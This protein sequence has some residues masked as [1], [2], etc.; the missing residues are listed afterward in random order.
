MS[1]GQRIAFLESRL[2]KANARI[3]VLEARLCGAK[4]LAIDIPDWA[5]ALTRQER[6]LVEALRKA[7]PRVLS[8]DA[9]DRAIPHRDHAAERCITLIATVVS[10][11][12]RKI[13]GG[14]ERV[15]G[16]GYRLSAEAALSLSPTRKA[17]V[18]PD[19]T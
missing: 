15:P 1:E 12:R 2:R 18:I 19:F 9:L 4:V 5:W 6:A 10:R 14:I 8:D 16:L 13:P 17:T 3:V 11:A 7:Y